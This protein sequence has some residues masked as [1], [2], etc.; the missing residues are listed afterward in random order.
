MPTTPALTILIV[1][2]D[3]RLREALASLLGR[4]SDFRVVGA[5]GTAAEAIAMADQLRPRV[6][7][8]DYHLSDR[9]GASVAIVIRAVSSEVAILFMS[10]DTSVQT[11]IDVALA[12]GDGFLGKWKVQDLPEA[13]R[14]V[15]SGEMVID[16]EDL[17]RMILAA[18]RRSR[19]E[20][21]IAG[22]K[23]LPPRAV[24]FHV[25]AAERASEVWEYAP[26]IPPIG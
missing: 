16:P 8:L 6:V 11:L 18:R 4:F 24:R 14:R 22:P 19:G 2:D 9:S 5:V 20:E 23:P 7:L 1:D 21:S 10:S 12:G 13:I 25:M 17:S 3:R 26:E 15:A